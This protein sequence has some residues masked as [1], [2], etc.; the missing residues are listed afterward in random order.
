MLVF[1]IYHGVYPWISANTRVQTARGRVDRLRN[2]WIEGVVTRGEVVTAAQQ[3]RNLTMVNS[4]LVSSSLILLGITTNL[5][6]RLPVGDNGVPHPADWDLHPD[7]LRIKLYLLIVVFALA[8]SFFM[9]ALRHLGHFVLVIGADPQVVR[10]E[11]GPPTEYFGDLINRA[12]HR[13]TLGVRSF[14]AAFTILAWLFDARLFLALTALWA[15]KFVGWQDFVRRRRG[16][17]GMSAG[18]VDGFV[19]AAGEW[20]D[21]VAQLRA[22]MLDCGMDETVK[23]RKPC[24][25]F[26]GSNVAII[27]PFSDS[28]ALMF[29]KGALLRDPHSVLERPGPNSH[30]GRRLKFKSV[31]EVAAHE[32]RIR[33]FIAQA[34]EV[35]KAGLKVET[36]PAPEPRPAELEEAFAETPGLEGAFNALTP[37][38]Q[39]GYILHFS[40]AKQST[41]RRARV[42]KYVARILAGKGMRD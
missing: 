1:P 23:W 35:E 22:I 19:R 2:S 40:G 10:E 13:Y 28:C 4:I 30:V 20:R 15:L 7:A 41:T 27:Q 12:S 31:E 18:A 34:I 36:E 11:F 32:A 33:E 16:A 17:C 25:G 8:F 6:I 29:F 9:T 37:G 5:L 38:R 39:R 14:Y 3:T 26:E 21:V 24:Y 42:D